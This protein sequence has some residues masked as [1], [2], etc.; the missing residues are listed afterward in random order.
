MLRA[1]VLDRQIEIRLNLRK[2]QLADLYRRE[3]F[4]SWVFCSCTKCHDASVPLLRRLDPCSL[5]TAY[6]HIKE[7]SQAIKEQPWVSYDQYCSLYREYLAGNVS[8]FGQSLALHQPPVVPLRSTP[9]FSDDLEQY[10]SPEVQRQPEGSREED[11]EHS[12]D[13]LS[14]DSGSD[15]SGNGSSSREELGPVESSQLAAVYGKKTGLLGRWA[16]W[17]AGGYTEEDD[18]HDAAQSTTFYGPVNRP[19]ADELRGRLPGNDGAKGVNVT[20]EDAQGS[21][22]NML[23]AIILEV[24]LI[25]CLSTKPLVIMRR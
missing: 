24:C 4:G 21:D 2:R 11:H 17:W 10:H 13:R 1:A 25:T 19:S 9:A 18:S 7:Y 12:P 15:G 20:L 22:P 6:I 3:D 14:G 16:R 23:P 5:R 8:E